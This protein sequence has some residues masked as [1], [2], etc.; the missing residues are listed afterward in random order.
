MRLTTPAH[1]LREELRKIDP[2]LSLNDLTELFGKSYN[3]ILKA[4]KD[5]ELKAERD[6][7]GTRVRFS[8]L[9]RFIYEHDEKNGYDRLVIEKGA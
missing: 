2:A 4:I 9:E 6:G 3:T 5:G 8:E 1:I 7:S